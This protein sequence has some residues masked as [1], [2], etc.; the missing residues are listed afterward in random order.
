[1]ISVIVPIYNAMAYLPQLIK[2]FDDQT[3]QDFE[4][5]L[6][7][8]NSTDGSLEALEK[9]QESKKHV[10]VLHA[11]EQGPNHARLLG[12]QNAVGEYV[13]FCDSDDHVL[14]QT[15]E[16]FI[17]TAIAQNSDV[18][19][20]DYCE[21]DENGVVQKRCPGINFQPS[22]E[23]LKTD[24]R[25]F[26]VKPPL[27]NKFFRRSIIHDDFF[28]F[29]KIGEDMLLSLSAIANSEKVCYQNTVVYHYRVSENGLSYQV[30]YDNIVGILDTCRY[31]N[32]ILSHYFQ[33]RYLAEMQYIQ[34]QHILYRMLRSVLIP[35]KALKWAAHDQLCD[36]LRS[37]PYKENSY[38]KKSLPF[39]MANRMLYGNKMYLL[40]SPF[41]K[42]LFTNRLLNTV[43][44][45]LDK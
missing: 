10:K 14:P 41:L 32:N 24:E 4:L 39:K 13:Y 44:K 15:L 6:V 18:V 40:C 9:Y 17:Q 20:A 19:I 28:V 35:D 29:S 31:M 7:D 22:A 43:F 3:C 26:L 21:T 30:S 36:Y 45:R 12:F 33:N 11:Y 27:W 16:V 8:N 34:I 2:S 1:M 38:F 42:L 23:N 25:I 37:F 5:L